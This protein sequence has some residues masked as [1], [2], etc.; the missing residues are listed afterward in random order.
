[1]PPE[2]LPALY[3][4]RNYVDYLRMNE[5]TARKMIQRIDR[6]RDQYHKSYAGYLPHDYAHK[7]LLM[8]SSL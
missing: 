5:D 1:M 6:V 2:V 7:E 4:L 3:W 8:D